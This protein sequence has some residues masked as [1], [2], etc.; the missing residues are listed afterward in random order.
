MQQS[1]NHGD[2]VVA[3]GDGSGAMA[4]GEACWADIEGSDGAQPWQ[5]MSNEGVDIY[6]VRGEGRSTRWDK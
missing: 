4:F 3:S 1:N 5:K 6:V 2:T